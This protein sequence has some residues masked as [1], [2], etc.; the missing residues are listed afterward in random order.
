MSSFTVTKAAGIKFSIIY[1]LTFNLKSTGDLM[2]Y[3]FWLESVSPLWAWIPP[4]QL[5]RAE[6][7]CDDAFQLQPRK[8]KW[9]T[10][11]RAP[12]W[13]LALTPTMRRNASLWSRQWLGT[14]HPWS[15]SIRVHFRDKRLL[16][17][18]QQKQINMLND[19]NAQSESSVIEPITMFVY[20][21]L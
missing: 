2:L 6:P 3:H 19:R 5:P 16:P 17:T 12:Y 21:D 9:S 4:F 13:T 11:L 1:V 7:S 15:R 14:P 20:D 18:C 8:K 10:M